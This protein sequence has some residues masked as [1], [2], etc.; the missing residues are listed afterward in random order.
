MKLFRFLPLVL[1]QVVRHRV[2]SAL[3]IAGIAVAMF[4]FTAVQAMHRGVER[5]TVAEAGDTELVVYRQDRFCPATSKLP[6]DYGAWI[7]RL[8]GVRT[9]VP[10]AVLV[11]N[12]RA[13][14]DVVTFRGVPKDG[15]LDSR[16]A[17]FEVLEGSAEDWLRRTDAALVGETLAKR[18]GL[19]PGMRFDAAGVTAY[20][21]GIIRSADPGDA[22][23]AYT[24]LPF[25]QLAGRDELGVVT[26]FNVRVDDPQQLGPVAAAIDERFATDREPTSTWTEKAFVGRIADDVVEL[27]GFARWL[28]LGCLVA[29]L[30]LVGNAIVLGVQGRVAEHAVLQTLGFTGRAVA[31]LIVAE[32]V[33]VAVIGGLIG[34]AAAAALTRWGSF[35]L[36][37]EGQSVPITADWK[38]LLT[39]LAVCGVLAVLAGLVPAVQAGRREIAEGFRAA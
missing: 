11:S 8:D 39:G 16:D 33:V 25:V 5:V 31:A 21:A 10:T 34:A 29:V 27:V 17:T 19:T 35:A 1:K 2:R 28:G 20:V 14:L 7:G 37:V 13:S 30:A 12:C 38:L 36:S 9:V 3:T 32:G 4:L 22:N 15:F 23:V 24:A 6:E 18:R 26:Q